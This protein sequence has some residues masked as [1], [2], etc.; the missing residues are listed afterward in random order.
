MPASLHLP[1]EAIGGA[2]FREWIERSIWDPSAVHLMA[3]NSANPCSYVSA[4]TSARGHRPFV[5]RGFERSDR[6]VAAVVE[7]GLFVVAAD[8]RVVARAVQTETSPVLRSGQIR[9]PAQDRASE[10]AARERPTN[11]ELVHVQRVPWG[12]RPE[13]FVPVEQAHGGRRFARDARD[14]ESACL[15]RVQEAR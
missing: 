2:G 9:G 7:P 6:D 8:A 12:A 10:V 11:G 4:R 13:S 5:Q 3:W 14:V 1:A 15:D